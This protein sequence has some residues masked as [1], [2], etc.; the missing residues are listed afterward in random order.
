MKKLFYILCASLVVLACKKGVDADKP[1]VEVTATNARETK[2]DT[3]IYKLGDT[4]KFNISG[5]AD[6]I[7]FW[8]GN[9]GSLYSLRARNQAFG[10]LQLSFTTTAANGTQ[11]ATLK[12]LA[13]TNLKNLDSVTLYNADWKDITSRMN[14]ATTSTAVNTGTVD[15]TDLVTSPS[16][17][18]FLAFRYAGQTG[19][20]QRT[21]VISNFSFNSTGADFNYP[22]ITIAN[23]VSY[24]T[25]Y[26]NVWAPNGRKW[27]P[28]SS[29]L[30]IAGGDATQPNNVSW[31][32]SKPLYVNRV[33]PDQPTAIVKNLTAATPN[34]FQYKY[35]AVGVYKVSFVAYNHTVNDTKTVSKDLLIKVSP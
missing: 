22:L 28:T 9:V 14:L 30:T 18:L 24:W 19:T 26:G 10:K 11:A 15:V 27:I 29:S 32:V 33:V 21:W 25:V 20:A 34:F 31:L 13:I 5:Y 17:V 1:T 7:T 4:C 12:V 3:L 2:G 23:D 8:S 6:N 16:D 35:A